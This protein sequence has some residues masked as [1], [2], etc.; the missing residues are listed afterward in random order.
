MSNL[1]KGSKTNGLESQELTNFQWETLL[2]E[3]SL[4]PLATLG[5]GWKVAVDL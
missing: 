1:V 5:L 4:L 2:P 3:I